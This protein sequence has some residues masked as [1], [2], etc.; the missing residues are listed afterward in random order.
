MAMIDSVRLWCKIIRT[1]LSSPGCGRVDA[2]FKATQNALS[3]LQLV[4]PPFENWKGGRMKEDE[5]GWGRMGGG[6][7]ETLGKSQTEGKNSPRRKWNP[8]T[9]C[10]LRLKHSNATYLRPPGGG[11]WKL[12]QLWGTSDVMGPIP[13]QRSLLCGSVEYGGGMC[14]FNISG[15]ISG[16]VEGVVTSPPSHC[17]CCC[18]CCCCWCCWCCCCCCCRAS[19]TCC[20]S[21]CAAT[22]TCWMRGGGGGLIKKNKETRKSVSIRTGNGAG[23]KE[24]DSESEVECGCRADPQGFFEDQR[25]LRD[26]RGILFQDWRGGGGGGGGGG[27]KLTST[28]C[29]RWR[30]F[31]R[32]L[33]R[34]ALGGASGASVT[35]PVTSFRALWTRTLRRICSSVWHSVETRRRSE[36]A[37]SRRLARGS[38]RKR[39]GSEALIRP[40][41][42]LL[43]VPVTGVAMTISTAQSINLL[44]TS[45]H[46]I[47]SNPIQSNPI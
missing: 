31:S 34:P 6:G 33:L 11:S 28:W 26:S 14:E 1:I 24:M 38:E 9:G 45:H 2:G 21:G 44:F 10:Q 39:L 8:S 25:F 46:P 13:M 27:E 32:R 12:F 30:R 7:G 22:F 18:C 43:L 23:D 20:C 36:V 41:A 29:L 42:R 4:S 17:C 5:G 40:E 3:A 19:C 16:D 35:S 47:Q 37:G 15:R